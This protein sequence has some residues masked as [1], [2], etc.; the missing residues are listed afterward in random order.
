[1]IEISYTCT[2]V[3]TLL[4]Q[5]Y[6]PSLSYLCISQLLWNPS[7][8]QL[9]GPAGPS[10][11]IQVRQSVV[12]AACVNFIARRRRSSSEAPPPP[13]STDTELW[14]SA[15]GWSFRSF[16][17]LKRK[18]AMNKKRT[19]RFFPFYPVSFRFIQFYSVLFRFIPFFCFIPFYS[20]LFCVLFTVA[21][22]GDDFFGW[23]A[24]VFKLRPKMS[25]KLIG[26]LLR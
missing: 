24:Y 23:F 4:L 12:R 20:L 6:H 1:M 11:I 2:Y 3:H 14:R 13:L 7:D 8:G 9:L 15:L 10:W 17:N 25:F 5:T 21:T 22:C 16:V 26:R 18:T 19:F